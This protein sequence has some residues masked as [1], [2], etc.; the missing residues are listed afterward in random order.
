[1]TLPL[2]TAMLI[3]CRRKLAA[4]GSPVATSRRRPNSLTHV[5]ASGPQLVIIVISFKSSAYYRYMHYLLLS[6]KRHVSY[7]DAVSWLRRPIAF[8]F[9]GQ[10][11]TVW[12]EL[13]HSCTQPTPIW[14]KYPAINAITVLQSIW[15]RELLMN[16]KRIFRVTCPFP[17]LIST[18]NFC[19]VFT[20]SDC[21]CTVLL[22]R[23]HADFYHSVRASLKNGPEGRTILLLD[24]H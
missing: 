15:L 7:T 24:L 16:L 4:L 3:F 20:R 19:C 5:L 22:H 9:H 2:W 21:C 13:D 23:M 18:S 14:H 17:R 10:A 12:E 8:P 6:Q 11:R 1:M